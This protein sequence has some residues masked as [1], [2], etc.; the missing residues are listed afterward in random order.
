LDC[1]PD[2]VRLTGAY[3]ACASLE[4]STVSCE[5]G[6]TGF[7]DSFIRTSSVHQYTV[8][9][10]MP[11]F[12]GPGRY[13]LTQETGQVD[14]YDDN[15]AEWRSVAGNLTIVDPQGQSGTVDATLAP[16]VGNVSAMSMRISGP[17]SC[18]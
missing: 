16:W 3:N 6:T 2:Q 17:W 15:N 5:G 9:I 7:D 13:E 11:P 8:E 12:A 4:T 18:G 1:T 14:F 10:E